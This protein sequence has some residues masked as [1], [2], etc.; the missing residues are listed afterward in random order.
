MLGE[1]GES[2]SAVVRKIARFALVDEKAVKEAVKDIQRA[3]LS[4]DVKVDFVLR[5]SKRIEERALKEKPRGGLSK[6]E[7][8]ITIVYEELAGLLGKG[9]RPAELRGD[10]IMMVGLQGSGKTTTVVKLAK[11][12]AKRGR[13]P[14]II[15]AD[16][17]RPA[18]YEQLV[19]L[20][21]PL[22]IKVYGE[23]K[24][25]GLDAVDLVRRG[26][27]E[28][29]GD[30]VVILDTA[31]R[32]KSQEELFAEMKLIAEVFR[33]QE[34][35]LVIDS[36]MGQQAGAQARAFQEMIGITGVILTKLDGSA[37]GG[38]ALSAV[39]E[40]SSPILFLG[41]GERIDDLEAFDSDR[42]I[43]RL[44]GMGDLKAL[45]ERA[46]ETMDEEKAAEILKGEFTLRELRE[47][48]EAITKMGPLGNVLKLIPGMPSLPG[49]ADQTEEKMK[50]FLFIIDSMTEEERRTAK[51]NPSRVRRIAAGSGTRPEDVK[52]LLEYYGTMRKA[53]RGLRRGRL[54]KGPLAK[55][56]RGLG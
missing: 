13:R 45:L 52:E 23:K 48:I 26:M 44:L 10:R 6:K 29:R 4:A 12:Y 40:T 33:P 50:R 37:K 39:A 7:Q 30:V 28:A 14:L 55:M 25:H 20:A 21:E 36:S 46:R 16:T 8:V 49:M 19:Q 41:I 47:Q 54:A 22:G 38:G 17:Q 15:A 31:G 42:F 51:L 1:L 11:F 35:L 9:M 53:L 27:E 24:A 34:K 3:L 18:A 43:S 32:H 56:L 2:L 5:I